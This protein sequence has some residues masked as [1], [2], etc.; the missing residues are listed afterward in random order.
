MLSF[1]FDSNLNSK[2]IIFMG[3]VPIRVHRTR[4]VNTGLRFG[5]GS[6][7]CFKQFLMPI[8]F[9]LKLFFGLLF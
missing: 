4:T 3:S 2:N 9:I 7:P 1:G 8:L 6:T 5:V